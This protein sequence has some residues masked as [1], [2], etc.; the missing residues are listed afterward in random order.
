M[1]D[2]AVS[3][4][5]LGRDKGITALFD[6][7]GRAADK[8]SRK[9]EDSFNRV[10]RSSDRMHNSLRNS[11]KAG[12]KLGTIVK[13]ILAAN[14]IRGGIGMIG[15]SI[16]KLGTDFLEFD[17]TMVSAAAKFDDIG[18]SAS[19]F[20]GEL[21]RLKKEWRSFALGSRY[22]AAQVAKSGEVMAESGWG[23]RAA[24]GV[25]PY[26]LKSA[27]ANRITDLNEYTDS[28]VGIFQGFNLKTGDPLKDSKAFVTILDQ[29][30]QGAVDARGGIT[31]LKES[32]KVLA[33]VWQ[34]SETSAATIAFASVLQNAGFPGDM[35]ATAG[36]NAKMRLARPDIVAGLAASGID[37]TDKATGKMKPLLHLYDEITAKMKEVGI[38]PGSKEESA[39]NQTLFGL[40][41]VAGNKSML[42]HLADY[43]REIERVQNQ[44]VGVAGKTSDLIA[45][46]STWDKLIVLVTTSMDKGFEVLERF[47]APGQ[48]GIEGLTE[49]IKNFNPRGFI[50]ALGATAKFVTTLYKLFEPFL[51]ILPYLI[52]GFT[53]WSLVVKPLIAM[54]GGVWGWVTAIAAAVSEMGIFGGMVAAGGLIIGGIAAVAAALVYLELRFKLVSRAVKWLWNGLVTVWDVI[55]EKISYVLGLLGKLA[56]VPIGFVANLLG[57][58]ASDTDAMLRGFGGGQA[59]NARE[60]EARAGSWN[61]T[62]T[63]AGAPSGSSVSGKSTGMSS[64]EMHM[65]GA[66]P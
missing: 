29:I 43:R 20:G 30:T 41:A 54:I 51:P 35:V 32:L 44:S 17:D 56:M 10:S 49:K 38:V 36:K 18:M 48:K 9:A 5:F 57:W 47:N 37:V 26:L 27:R 16:Q 23:S 45:Q 8:F 63:I 22:S 1:P 19:N 40:Y 42:Q 39:I 3:T 55:A 25:T 28:M 46:Y 66:N 15:G 11:S 60:A 59:P 14:A 7:M 50:E 58:N 61:G 64:F 2:Y 24:A 31:D 33:P 13:G 4:A 52:A 62:L 12:Y 65:L 53:T 6:K 21:I 34:E